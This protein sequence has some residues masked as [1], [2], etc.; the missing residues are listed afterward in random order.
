M[1]G[2]DFP[3]GAIENGRAYI[4]R[5]QSQ[6]DFECQAGPLRLCSDFQELVRCFEYMAEY[7]VSEKEGKNEDR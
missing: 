7:L 3:H 1:T 6:Y 5:L 4:E 2:P